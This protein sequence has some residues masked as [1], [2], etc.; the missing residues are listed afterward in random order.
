MPSF[1]D[2]AS[3]PI[4]DC[5]APRQAIFF[6]W[7]ERPVNPAKIRNGLLDWSRTGPD[8]GIFFVNVIARRPEFEASAARLNTLDK[9]DQILGFLGILKGD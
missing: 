6:R 9:A 1:T 4:G 8:P 3:S 5:N 7:R 2:R